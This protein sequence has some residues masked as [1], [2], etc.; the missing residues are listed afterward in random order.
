VSRTHSLIAALVVLACCTSREPGRQDSKR[1]PDQREQAGEGAPGSRAEATPAPLATITS[2][3][4][5]L[6]AL[7]ERRVDERFGFELAFPSGWTA[8]EGPGMPALFVTSARE[9]SSDAFVENVNVVVEPLPITMSA[10]AYADQ[11]APLMQTDL[12]E[13]QELSRRSVELAGQPA[14]RREYQHTFAGRPLWAVSYM[15]VVEQQAFVITAT[16]ERSTGL[17]GWQP[18]LDS[19]AASFRIVSP[20]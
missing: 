11:S 2:A 13:Y 5:E 6:P 12:S 9:S 4:V 20:R 14:V 15:L 17:A 7:S 10:E 18:V 8:K 3:G 1:A 16:A 19:V